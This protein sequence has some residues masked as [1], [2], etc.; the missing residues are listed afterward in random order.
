MRVHTG[1][2]HGGYGDEVAGHGVQGDTRI[3]H[4]DGY[5][6][7]SALTGQAVEVFNGSGW[8]SVVPIRTGTDQSLIRVRFSDGSNLACTADQTFSIKLRRQAKNWVTVNAGDL[9]KGH[10]L[11]TFRIP[12]DIRGAP[13]PEAYTYGA[14][15]GDGGVE[16]RA[17]SGKNR[18]T[19]GLYRGKHHL[20]VTGTRGKEGKNG[21]V[22]VTVSHLDETKLLSLKQDGFPDWVFALDHDSMLQFLMGLFDTDGTF[23]RDT[24]GIRFDTSDGIIATDVQLLLRRVGSSYASTGRWANVGDLTN[25]GPRKKAM[26]RVYV[27]EC[28]AALIQGHR[29]RSDRPLALGRVSRQAR[30]EE[31]EELPGLHHTYSFDEPKRNMAV[32]QNV[33]AAARL[34]NDVDYEALADKWREGKIGGEM[35]DA[36]VGTNL[37]DVAG[38]NVSGPPFLL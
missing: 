15:Q 9:R 35:G 34:V 32:F 25:F 28:E 5:D 27:P 37:R 8:A 16:R 23:N 4:R 24:G 2:C 36:Y 12:T 33:L 11:P 14:F 21:C 22:V 10:I 17:D 38:L 20:P 31:L 26:F 1:E 13:E 18:Y 29:V 7:I 3:L 6:K 19:I 30:V